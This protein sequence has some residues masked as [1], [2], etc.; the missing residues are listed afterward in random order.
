MTP[1]LTRS[2]GFFCR[3]TT[4]EPRY[5][6]VSPHPQSPPPPLRTNT[7]YDYQT[8]QVHEVTRFASKV[9]T[10]SPAGTDS[11]WLQCGQ[12]PPSRHRPM[13]HASRPGCPCRD[14]ES[15]LYRSY[16]KPLS[17]AS[18]VVERFLPQ[19]A[20]RTPNLLSSDPRSGRVAITCVYGCTAR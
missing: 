16:Q 11:G 15:S 1:R 5:A 9:R 4:T 18:W 20:F 14:G 17:P 3:E 19:A 10:S 7:N 12:S 2:E 8:H 13:G 6:A